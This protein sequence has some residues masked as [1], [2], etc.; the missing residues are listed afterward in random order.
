ML[1]RNSGVSHR[2]SAVG[3]TIAE[4]HGSHLAWPLSVKKTQTECSQ[5]AVLEPQNPLEGM[6]TE[7]VMVI[8]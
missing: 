7:L 4:H 5:A 3:L 1:Y 6:G 8:V 2:P